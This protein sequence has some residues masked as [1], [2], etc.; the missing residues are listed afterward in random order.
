[1]SDEPEFVDFDSAEAFLK[2]AREAH[3]SGD[4]QRYM[5]ARR[6]IAV[7]LD[8]TDMSGVRLHTE[9]LRP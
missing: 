6:L 8:L 7:A 4:R 9:H 3:E 2:I 1:M 5:A